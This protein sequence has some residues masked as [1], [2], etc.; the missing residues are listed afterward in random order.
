M[1]IELPLIRHLPLEM[2]YNI[3][4]STNIVG[5]SVRVLVGSGAAKRV[6]GE[7]EIG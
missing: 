3:V 4:Q 5:M 7:R 1:A 2:R 6:W